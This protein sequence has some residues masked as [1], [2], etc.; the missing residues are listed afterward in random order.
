MDAKWNQIK[1]D[2]IYAI[3]WVICNKQLYATRNI[4]NGMTE[5]IKSWHLNQFRG[6]AKKK[7]AAKYWTLNAEWINET[8]RQWTM[9]VKTVFLQQ[10]QTFYQIDW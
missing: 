1:T 3:T 4:T 8:M 9:L 2:F 10:I 7:H 6:I 5:N